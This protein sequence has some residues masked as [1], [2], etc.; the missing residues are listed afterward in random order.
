[1]RGELVSIGGRRHPG[2]AINVTSALSGIKTEIAT[3]Q[4]WTA[5]CR[6][7]ANVHVLSVTFPVLSIVFLFLGVALEF[8]AQAWMKKRLLRQKLFKV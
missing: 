5:E 8:L 2:A 1:M 7:D 3:M 6:A 4:I